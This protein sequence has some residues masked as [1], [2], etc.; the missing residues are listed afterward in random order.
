MQSRT[1]HALLPI[2]AVLGGLAALPA[3]AA[4]GL[5]VNLTSDDSHRAHMALTFSQKVLETGHP[6]T[7]FLNVDSVKIAAKKAGK[8][9]DNQAL[10]SALVKGGA[11]ILA[12][13]HC[14]EHAGMKPGDLMG[15]VKMGTPELVQGALF[16]PGA[17]SLSW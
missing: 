15:G 3:R 9:K 2:L 7:V 12:C 8:H 5:F 4:D 6:V 1:R 14:V 10:L 11:T 16:E 17:R 13:P